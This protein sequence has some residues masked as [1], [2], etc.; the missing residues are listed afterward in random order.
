MNSILQSSNSTTGAATFG[1]CNSRNERLFRITPGICAEHALEHASLLMA[2]ANKLTLLS[3]LQADDD[4]A[5]V[6][7]A[8]YLGDM[9]KAIID[10][11]TAGLQDVQAGSAS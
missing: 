6:W 7:A 9:A 11:V 5:M 2:S 10:D 8:H 1:V 3:A 4:G